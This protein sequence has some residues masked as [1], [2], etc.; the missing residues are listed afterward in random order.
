ISGTL[1]LNNAAALGSG[2]FS[3]NGGTI[4]NTSTGDITLSSNG[5]V[6]IGG[7]FTFTGTHGLTFG[8]GAVQ[9]SGS[10]TITLGASLAFNG[11]LQQ[12]NDGAVSTL[13]VNGAGKA[14]SVTGW[15]VDSGGSGGTT[16]TLAGDGNI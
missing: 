11:N 10:K 6:A 2:T 9:Y 4:D 14:L 15:D 3:I 5:V 7:S 16:T 13:T 8:A 1:N 12:T